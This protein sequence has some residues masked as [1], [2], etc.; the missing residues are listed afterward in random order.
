MITWNEVKTLELAISSIADLADEIVVVDTGSTDG[1]SELAQRLRAQVILGGDRMHKAQSRN[2][3]M[4]AASGDWIVILDADERIADPAGLREFLESTDAQA[5]CIKLVYMDGSDMPTL[6]YPQMRCWRKGAFEYKYRAH[7]VPL[8]VNGWGKLAH[9]DFVWEHRPP[10]DQSWKAQY[11]L[12]RLLLDVEENP[13]SPRPLY[14]LG[15]QHLYCG[16]WEKGV[17]IL[18]Q[19]LDTPGRHDRADAWYHLAKCYGK[20]G[21]RVEQVKALHQACAE[22]PMRREWW[23]ALASVYHADGKDEIAVGLLKCA[24]EIPLPTNTYTSYYWY[25]QQIH[26]LLARCLWKLT[27]YKE[28]RRHAKRALDLL[29]GDTRLKK[30][31]AF[32]EGKIK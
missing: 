2:S 30:N 21:R 16:Q 24:L 9:T 6:T 8:P 27:R 14:Y 26:D 25:G 17:E 31:L 15:R 5:V 28:G 3:A 10:K 18:R 7:E 19:Y 23:G 22:R 13:D 32:F 29:P 20:L 4:Q 11:T 12:E 1:T